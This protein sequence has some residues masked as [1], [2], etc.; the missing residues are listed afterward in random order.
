MSVVDLALLLVAGI[1]AFPFVIFCIECGF[2][3]FPARLLGIDFSIDP[4]EV[5]IVIPAHN[6]ALVI[7]TTLRRLCPTLLPNQRVLVVADNCDDNTASIAREQGCHVIERFDPLRRGKG[8]ALQYGFQH[9]KL[10]HR[11]FVVIVLDADC[12]VAPFTVSRIAGLAHERNRPVQA[13]N[14]SYAPAESESLHVVSE[15][16]FRFK[17]LIRPLGL[18]RLGL[19]CHLMGTGMAIPWSLLRQCRVSGEHL[20]EDM[21]LGLDLALAGHPALF[22]PHGQVLSELPTQ[23]AG[24]MSQRTRWEQGHLRTSLTQIPRLLNQ[25]VR[26]WNLSLLTLAFDLMIPPFS[27]L[28]LCLIGSVLG[29]ACFWLFGAS[30]YAIASIALC[31]GGHFT[32]CN[33]RLVEILQAADSICFITLRAGLYAEED[34]NLHLISLWP[35]GYSVDSHRA[36]DVF[37]APDMLVIPCKP[38][39]CHAELAAIRSKVFL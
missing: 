35:F 6:E 28:I 23:N 30:V 17:N 13:L 27:L 31:G 24:F 19:P 26:K 34:S 3:F 10:N 14:L 16:G 7:G 2:A 25:G 36:R 1:L 21:N 18:T 22:C 33:L 15:L 20:A 9:L 37:N 8:F 29:T 4:G 11:P 5:W 39:I 38:C 12:R 32:Y